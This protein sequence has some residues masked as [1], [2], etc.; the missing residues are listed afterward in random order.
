MELQTQLEEVRAT[1]SR[2]QRESEIL[3]EN[4][5]KWVDEQ[6]CVRVHDIRIFEELNIRAQQF[7][8]NV[9]R[10]KFLKCVFSLI[11]DYKLNVKLLLA[12]F[13]LHILA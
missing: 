1:N 3:I 9:F 6:K 4:I 2:L 8:P 10:N 13:N 7:M 11:T 5:D 12:K